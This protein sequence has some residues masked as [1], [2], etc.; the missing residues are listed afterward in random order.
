M[1]QGYKGWTKGF[2]SDIRKGFCACGRDNGSHYKGEKKTK[3]SRGVGPNE[4]QGR[5]NDEKSCS[6]QKNIKTNSSRSH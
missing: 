1:V 2:T 5:C 3:T 6:H 4:D